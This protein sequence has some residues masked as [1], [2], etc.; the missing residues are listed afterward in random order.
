MLASK[1]EI[2]IQQ[3]VVHI[4]DSALGMPVLS[5]TLLDCG[6]DFSDFLKSHIFKIDS[7]DEIKNCSFTEE[8][9]VFLLVR[10]GT[11]RI[12]WKCRKKLRESSILL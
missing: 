11:L 10:N 6:S 12:F 7:S 1:E 4:L 2:K 9:S 8:S 3:A 5:D